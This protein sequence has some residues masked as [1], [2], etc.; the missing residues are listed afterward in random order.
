MGS[1]TSVRLDSSLEVRDL[2]QSKA[3]P[4]QIH[5]YNS[6]LSTTSKLSDGFDIQHSHPDDPVLFT[7][8]IMTHGWLPGIFFMVGTFSALSPSVQATQQEGSCGVDA[9]SWWTVFPY[10]VSQSEILKPGKLMLNT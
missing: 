6:L 4:L 3:L 5:L 7:S 8:S 1:P 10:M 2:L 9:Y